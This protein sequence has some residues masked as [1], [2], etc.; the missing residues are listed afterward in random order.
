MSNQLTISAAFSVLAMAAFA[1]A[2][3]G[4]GSE[5]G[6]ALA[7]AIPGIVGSS[8]AGEIPV[9]SFLACLLT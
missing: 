1:V 9:L 6:P 2:S 7:T 8:G 4:L 5:T 3:P